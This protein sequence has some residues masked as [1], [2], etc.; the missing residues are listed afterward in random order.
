M[1][2]HKNVENQA[3]CQQLTKLLYCLKLEKEKG[4]QKKLCQE[5]KLPT[6]EKRLQQIVRKTLSPKNKKFKKASLLAADHKNYRLH[7]TTTF[8]FRTD[9]QWQKL[10]V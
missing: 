3:D 9:A 6:T 7:W 5:L 10:I 1:A 2:K 4:Q 8:L